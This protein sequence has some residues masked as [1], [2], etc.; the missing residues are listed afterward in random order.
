[1]R[2]WPFFPADLRPQR[3]VSW[4]VYGLDQPD[5]SLPIIESIN[6]FCSRFLPDKGIFFFSPLSPSACSLGKCCVSVNQIIK[7]FGALIGKW[8][9]R[10]LLLWI[11]PLQIKIDWL[12]LQER[13]T[14][15]L[16]WTASSRLHRKWT[17]LGM[18]AKSFSSVSL[19][20]F[21]TVCR[22]ADVISWVWVL[23]L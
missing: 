16:K 18:W 20:M 21:T 3:T 23:E 2:K 11:G 5:R 14:I 12:Y 15:K 7:E 1:M 10:W 17:I 9:E 6:R 19:P 22:A 4:W 8:S 13:V